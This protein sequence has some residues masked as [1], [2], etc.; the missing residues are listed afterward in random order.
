MRLGR[1]SEQS[2]SICVTVNYEA[3]L[4]HEVF[5]SHHQERLLKP[6]SAFIGMNSEMRELA[7]VVSRVRSVIQFTIYRGG[8]GLLEHC[9]LLLLLITINMIIYL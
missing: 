9:G 2:A 4:Y 6:L 7:A 3:M 1:R 8:L 5:C